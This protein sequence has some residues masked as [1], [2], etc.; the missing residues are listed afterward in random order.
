LSLFLDPFCGK[1]V[2]DRPLPATVA[3]CYS[4]VSPLLLRGYFAVLARDI[5]TKIAGK[6]KRC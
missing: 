3:R 1:D 4:A 6:P 2:A 5:E